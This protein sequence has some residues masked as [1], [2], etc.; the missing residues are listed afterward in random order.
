MVTQAPWGHRDWTLSTQLPLTCCSRRPGLHGRRQRA[1]HGVPASSHLRG[2]TESGPGLRERTGDGM[3]WLSGHTATPSL[4]APLP[5]QVSALTLR[6]APPDSAET[7]GKGGS[8]VSGGRAQAPGL[9]V[10]LLHHAPLS[11]GATG[12]STA[13]K[14]ESF[15][16]SMSCWVNLPALA[17]SMAFMKDCSVSVER[18]S[19]ETR[20]VRH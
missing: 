15:A 10:C 13:E 7:L 6:P 3:G 8:R 4:H 9:Q 20:G 18:G 12:A 2:R 1:A 5:P 17:Q 19:L 14:T 11:E 16:S